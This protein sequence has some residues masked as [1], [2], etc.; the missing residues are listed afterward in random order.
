MTPIM[1]QARINGMLF[2]IFFQKNVV[3]LNGCINQ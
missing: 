2:I 3:I 1:T